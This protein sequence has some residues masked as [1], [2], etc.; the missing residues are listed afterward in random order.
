ML[1]GAEPILVKDAVEQV[2]PA[3]AAFRVPAGDKQVLLVFT[4]PNDP[5]EYA[6][7]VGF[8]KDGDYSFTTDEAFFYEDPHQSF[9]FW[10]PAIW[11]GIDAHTAVPGMTERETQMALGQVSVPHGDQMGN[12]TVTFDDQGHPKNVTFVNNKATRIEDVK[13]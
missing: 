1:L 6:T 5:K 11:K 2:A 8:K 7:A 3:K 12:R 13:Q 10:G 9:S 4:R